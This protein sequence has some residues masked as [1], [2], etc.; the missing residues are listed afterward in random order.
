MVLPGAIIDDL[1]GDRKL[2]SVGNAR[3]AGDGGE[4]CGSRWT[5]LSN[6]DDVVLRAVGEAPLGVVRRLLVVVA[7]IGDVRVVVGPVHGLLGTGDAAAARAVLGRLR[8]GDGRSAR[9]AG[10]VAAEAGHVLLVLPLAWER[11][12]SGGLGEGNEP[13]HRHSTVPARTKRRCTLHRDTWA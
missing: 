4:G 10:N 6:A 3:L 12:G 5:A 9:A 2:A 1:R 11:G 7:G 13:S 8:R